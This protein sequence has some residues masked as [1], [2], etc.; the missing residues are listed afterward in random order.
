M[1]KRLLCAVVVS[2]MPAGGA[3]AGGFG[4]VGAPLAELPN[5]QAG[6]CFARIVTPAQYE[7]VPETVVVAEGYDKLQAMEPAF[8]DAAQEV[9]IREAGVEYVV[10]QPRWENRTEQVLVKPGFERLRIVPARFETR[11][12]TITVGEPRKV[13][14]AGSNLS[15]TR[16]VDERTGQVY[17][18]VEIP[19]ETR[20]VSRK[21]LVE[22]ERVERV[23]VDA[24][25]VTVNK[26]VMVD[27]GGVEERAT[28][29][30]FRTIPTQELVSPAHTVSTSVAPQTA[31]VERN[32][33][34]A[35]EKY[36]WIEVVCDTNATTSSIYDLQ[37]ALEI[38]GFYNG[39]IDGLFGP[40]TQSALESYQNSI[41]MPHQG[42]LTI[43]TLRSLGLAGGASPQPPSYQP[44]S[45]APAQTYDQNAG[46]YAA[47]VQT[48]TPVYIGEGIVV[49]SGGVGNGTSAPAERSYDGDA[50]REYS[51]RKRLDW[52]GK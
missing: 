9:M 41:G 30:Q 19:A 38:R 22:P 16:R 23:P 15:S 35:P 14:K 27:R 50:R 46:Q 40:Q 21:V 20:T 12:E 7:A 36:E 8:R 4:A 44:E 28:A 31:T 37:R 17:C 39:P 11:T 42:Y 32:V 2:A 26:Q 51:V 25:F 1:M 6:Q 34:R 24:Q 10:R 47:P 43:D 3:H 13:W 49:G 5:A 45:Y 33:L 52:D 29:P 18:L 48:D